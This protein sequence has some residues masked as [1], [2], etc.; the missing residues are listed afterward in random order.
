M[1]ETLDAI[2]LSIINFFDSVDQFIDQ[3]IYDLMSWAFAQFIELSVISFIDFVMWV[4][5][6]AWSVARQIII[7]FDLSALL[8]SAWSALPFQLQGLATVLKIPESVN[9]LI[10]AYFTRFVLRYIPFI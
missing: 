4:M 1:L 6:F 8:D 2:F 3:G 7:D 9:L 5:P 10:S